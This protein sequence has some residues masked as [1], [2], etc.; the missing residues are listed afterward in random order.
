MIDKNELFWEN[1]RVLVTGAT[2]FVGSWLV[3]T[4]LDRGAQ[5]VVLI[6]DFNRKS[7]LFLSGNISRVTTFKGSIENFSTVKQIIKGQDIKTIFHLASTNVNYGINFSPFQAF[8]TNI[9]GTYNLLEACRLYSNNSISIVI[10]SS[11]EVFSEQNHNTTEN[12]ESHVSHPYET[13]KRCVDMISLA[14]YKTYSLNVKLIRC[15]NIYGGGDF[16]WNRIIPGTIRSVIRGEPPV[17]RTSGTL[18]RSYFYILDIVEAFLIV[19][20]YS[21]LKTDDDIIYNFKENEPLSTL[22]I[23][24]KIIRLSQHTNLKPV[25]QNFSKDEK[26]YQE[27]SFK[28]TINDLGW[29]QKYNLDEGLRKTFNWYVTHCDTLTY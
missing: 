19:A 7:E 27:V 18:K 21:S 3:K 2:G 23:V 20:K 1:S 5:V 22:D 17:I 15:P 28:N 6:R 16:N 8:E 25:I 26:R 4:L 29:I 12:Y 11:K 14:Y 13:S 10:A 24:N 9:R